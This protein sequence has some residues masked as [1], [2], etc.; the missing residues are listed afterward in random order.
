MHCRHAFH[1]DCVDKW[2]QV[3]RNNC[4]ACRS[5]ASA[6]SSRMAS[7]YM[8]TESHST[9]GRVN[10]RRARA[11]IEPMLYKTP[12]I[13]FHHMD[14][15][16]LTNSVSHRLSLIDPLLLLSHRRLSPHVYHPVLTLAPSACISFYDPSRSLGRRSGPVPHHPSHS[17]ENALPSS[18]RVHYSRIEIRMQSFFL[19][20]YPAVMAGCRAA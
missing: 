17:L 14:V 10:C 8:L 3:G 16:I 2:L 11:L 5:K 4:P 15:F 1:K 20:S 6:T 7:Q 19:L 13:F 12:L 18:F 9:A